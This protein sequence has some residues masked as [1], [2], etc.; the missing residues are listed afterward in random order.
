[1]AGWEIAAAAAGVAF[2][3]FVGLLICWPRRY[4]CHQRSAARHV[5]NAPL[6]VLLAILAAM[7][8]GAMS[9][10]PLGTDLAR[11]IIRK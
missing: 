2:L 4:G 3:L 6:K 7:K 5:Q 10:P 9:S 11:S 1:M 8:G